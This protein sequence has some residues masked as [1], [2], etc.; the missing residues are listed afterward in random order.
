M[1]QY[2]KLRIEEMGRMSPEAFEMANK[3]P[4][5]VILDDI[6]SM[7]N[8]GALFRTS[9]AF[10]IEKIHLC[11]ITPRPPHREI[12][13]TAIGAEKSVSWEY[14]EHILPLIQQ[15]ISEGYQLIGVE[16]TEN[17]TP[18][19]KFEV[20]PSHKYALILGHEIQGVKQEVLDLCDAVVEI[21]QHGTKHSLNISVSAGISLFHFS[22]PF[23]GGMQE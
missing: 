3:I 7:H 10:R 2:R 21:P 23:F 8:V 5:R 15:L 12:H 9:D 6:R 1:S 11:G 14:H 20:N 13:K 4:V 16:Q 22:H 17:S 18:L 19:Q